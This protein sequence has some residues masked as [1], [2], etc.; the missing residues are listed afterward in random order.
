MKRLV[1]AAGAI[2]IVF[3]LL[4]PAVL[5]ADPLPT[6]GRVIVSTEGDIALPAG[7]HADVVMVVNGTATIEGEVNTLVVVDGSATLLGARA[8]TIVAVRSP[9]ELG[10]DTI[11]LGDVMAFEA[12]VHQ[13]GNAEVVGGVTDLATA[14]VGLGVAIASALLLVWIG[15]GLAILVAGLLLAGLASRQV[16]AAGAVISEEP[17]IALVVGIVGLFAFPMVGVALIA[18][19]IGAPLGL[20]LLLQVWPLVAFIGYLVAGIW[21]GD[22]VLRR[23]SPERIR[24]RP[25]LAS[26]VGLLIL[27]LVGLVPV[28]GLISAIASLFGFGAVMVL[29]FRTLRSRHVPQPMASGP[30]PAPMAS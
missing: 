3:A 25:Y 23:T 21:V 11:V 16:R 5:A 26:F 6:T 14:M 9:I 10:P 30:M 24:E 29:A 1:G 13:T 7:E 20:A 18:T 4:V 17:V 19:L 28:L 27:G 8:E 15:F 2:L 22:W 12:S